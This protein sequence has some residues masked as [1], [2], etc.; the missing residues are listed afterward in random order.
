MVIF[1]LGANPNA[2][3]FKSVTN[4]FI[5]SSYIIKLFSLNFNG[6][7]SVSELN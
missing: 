6:Y 5:L 7:L 2:I 4:F 1:L 3:L